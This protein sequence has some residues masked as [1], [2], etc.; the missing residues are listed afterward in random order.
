M[1]QNW[2]LDRRSKPTRSTHGKIGVSAHTATGMGTGYAT[3]VREVVAGLA[4]SVQ[5]SHG[6]CLE[7]ISTFDKKHPALIKYKEAEVEYD[8]ALV[9]LKLGSLVLL[10]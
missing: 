10:A 7:K 3:V 4:W 2:L 1:E 6:Y 5:E 8:N 9:K